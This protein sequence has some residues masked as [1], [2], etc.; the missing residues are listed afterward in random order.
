MVPS[1]DLD[2]SDGSM[3]DLA[4]VMS[5]AARR[6]EEEHGDVEGTLQAVT[7]TAVRV[8]PHAE[9]C[10]ISFVIGRSKIEPRASTS[11]LPREV[12]ALQ[13]RIGQGPCMDAVWEHQ[14]VRVDD[15][16]GEDRWPLFAPAAAELGVGSMMCYQ[17][18]VEGDQLGAMNLYARTPRVFDDESEGVGHMLAAHAAVAIA[19]A[20]H[21]QNLRIA[22]GTR[23]V[24]G[25][26][27]GILME[28]HKLTADQ[29]FGV[30]AQVSQEVNRKLVEVARE[31]T[32]TG[33]VPGSGRRRA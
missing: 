18:F 24:I 33:A 16:A 17:L 8:V 31:L 9:E 12:D 20:G 1:E 27:K 6:L 28:R 13:E 10:S 22:V 29:A 4:E 25:Q 3:H 7:A 5:R 32:E 21:E 26:A 2:R 14:V 23:D 30:L 15:V 19:G 11:D